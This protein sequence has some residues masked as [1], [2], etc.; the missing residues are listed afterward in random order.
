MTSLD[1]RR[2]CVLPGGYLDDD[3]V[4]HREAELAPLT[5]RE[6]ELLADAGGAVS[7]PELVTAILSRC[8][9]RIGSIQPVDARV[10]R[11]LL[12]ADRQ[13]LLLRLR[14]AT[15]GDRVEGT[16]ACPW[17]RCGSKV[18]VD[19]SLDDV[20]VERREALEPAYRVEL[21]RDEGAEGGGEDGAPRA[22]TFRL[23]RGA[24]QEALGAVLAE[25]PARALT[26]LLER[27]IVG[28]EGGPEDVG[29]WVA[30]LTPVARREIEEAM[31]A[32]SP[33]LDLEM[34]LTCP[35]CGRAFTAPFDL[36]DFFFGELRTGR[37]LLYRQV[38]YLAYHYHWSEREIL[39]MTRDKRLSYIEILAD[40]I[41][42]LNHAV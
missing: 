26:A 17:P 36:A 4:L 2:V 25:N 15:F 7:T 20:P 42:A 8:V 37:D 9:R 31:L 40:E 38:H 35:E 39:G 19:F 23:A 28:T 11:G 18:D 22:A 1:A 30:G 10:A 34:E 5:G 33:Q 6:E 3:G 41:E 13:Y 14:A 21:S 24:D 16:L 32:A 29:E 12:V 27:C